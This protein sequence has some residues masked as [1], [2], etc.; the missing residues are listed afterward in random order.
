MRRRTPDVSKL[1]EYIGHRPTYSTD[2]IICEIL[3]YVRTSAGAPARVD[4]AAVS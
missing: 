3:Q 2:D 4:R 1:Q